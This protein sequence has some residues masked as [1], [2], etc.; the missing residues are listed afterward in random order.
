MDASAFKRLLGALNASNDSLEGLRKKDFA[1]PA[2][3]MCKT[4]S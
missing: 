2:K 4:A 3:R 1:A